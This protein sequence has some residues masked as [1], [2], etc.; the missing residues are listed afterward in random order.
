SAQ[1][2]PMSKKDLTLSNQTLSR[3]LFL[4]LSLSIFL[5]IFVCAVPTT[6]QPVDRAKLLEDI[7]TL[8]A[9]IRNTTDPAELTA[10]RGQLKSKEKLFLAPAPE[11]FTA[12]AD[13]LK[14]PGTGLM[15]LLPRESFDEVLS[16][17]GGGAFFSFIN[18]V[19]DY[20]SGV[21][22]E[23]QV[24]H[25]FVGFHGLD[26]GFLASLGDTPLESVGLDTPGVSLLA[27]FTPLLDEPGAR[28]QKQRARAGFLDNGFFYAYRS[29]VSVE[30]TFVLRAVNYGEDDVLVVLRV[31]R[32]D[33]DGSL[34]IAWKLLKRYP[35]PQLNG[36]TLVTTSAASYAQ[37]NYARDM[38]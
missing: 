22:L 38:I 4:R 1:G 18:Q 35:T 17:E 34:I 15:R 7:I 36:Y 10:L 29:P 25:L 8:Q 30:T 27:S 23:L 31:H 20:D 32:Q 13:W 2:G 11:D 16:I 28:E 26:Y 14:Q 3:L 19:H 6:A 12:F 5:I 24:E 37:S 9:K 21:D 33:T